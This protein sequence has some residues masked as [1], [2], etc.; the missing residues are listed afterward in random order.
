MARALES[1]RDR[2]TY[3]FGWVNDAGDRGFT[4]MG[5]QLGKMAKRS[6]DPLKRQLKGAAKTLKRS[7]LSDLP[8]GFGQFVRRHPY[9]TA[10]VGTAAIYLMQRWRQS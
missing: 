9:A 5:K 1:A 4:A 6:P 3:F 2:G 7:D 10:L 8:S